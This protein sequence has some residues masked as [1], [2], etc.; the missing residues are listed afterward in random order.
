M[1][2]GVPVFCPF[3]KCETQR[4]ITCEGVIGVRSQNIF[5]KMSEKTKHRDEYCMS[6]NCKRCLMHQALLKKY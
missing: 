3:W 2:N 5:Y 4:S 1:V 6:S